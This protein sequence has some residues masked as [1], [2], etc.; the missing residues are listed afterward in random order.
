MNPIAWFA[1]KSTSRNE[2]EKWG[3]PIVMVTEK[4]AAR[5]SPLMPLVLQNQK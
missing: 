5:R 4:W 3:T 2:R 1:T